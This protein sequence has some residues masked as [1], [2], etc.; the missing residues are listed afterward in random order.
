MAIVALLS[1]ASDSVLA[2]RTSFLLKGMLK[3]TLRLPLGAV[4]TYRR[5]MEMLLGAVTE[6]AKPAKCRRD[7]AACNVN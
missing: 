7:L 1:A 6:H 3:A 2:G 5:G 4:L